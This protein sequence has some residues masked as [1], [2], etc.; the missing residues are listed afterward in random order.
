MGA[1]GRRGKGEGVRGG[2][3]EGGGVGRVVS[4]GRGESTNW[5][6]G[7]LLKPQSPPLVTYFLQQS[8]NF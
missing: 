7:R 2:G 8:L 4:G 5:E 6:K 3:R 1:R